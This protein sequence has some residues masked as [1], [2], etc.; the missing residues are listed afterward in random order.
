MRSRCPVIAEG[1]GGVEDRRVSGRRCVSTGVCVLDRRCVQKR[2]RSCW[3]Q[4][5]TYP[6]CWLHRVG[7]RLD[8]PRGGTVVW[9]ANPIWMAWNGVLI[10]MSEFCQ[11][12][13]VAEGRC[14]TI[15]LSGISTISL[16]AVGPAEDGGLSQD[17]DDTKLQKI[18]DHQ[19]PSLPR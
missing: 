17:A 7:T 14:I 12:Y 15:T 9:P 16:W 13:M 2:I 5:V 8:D 4:Y 1:E 10:I 18:R 6:F 11:Y 3:D 19:V